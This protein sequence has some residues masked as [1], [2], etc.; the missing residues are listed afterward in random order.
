[1]KEHKFM[2]LLLTMCIA[3]AAFVIPVY[4][5]DAAD[6]GYDYWNACA[7]EVQNEAVSV[8]NDYIQ[9][10]KVYVGDWETVAYEAFSES[11]Q[12]LK[13]GRTYRSYVTCCHGK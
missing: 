4:A 7:S 10:F 6:A 2:S 1:M 3:A 13:D 5:S 12:I 9:D 11:A 8:Y